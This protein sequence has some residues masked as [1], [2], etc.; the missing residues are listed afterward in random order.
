MVYIGEG[1]AAFYGPKLDYMAIDSLGREWQLATAQLDMNMPEMCGL[2][3]LKTVRAD[4]NS[5][6][7]P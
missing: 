4:P 1:E 3:V 2:D 5:N 7:I 6:N